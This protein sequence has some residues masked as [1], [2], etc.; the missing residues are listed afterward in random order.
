MSVTEG[1]T[2]SPAGGHSKD[3]VSSAG[4]HTVLCR[5]T[6]CPLSHQLGSDGQAGTVLLGQF[7]LDRFGALD[8]L[9]GSGQILWRHLQTDLIEL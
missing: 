8:R 5:G 4:R 7:D 6:Q 3:T 1:D 9:Q 2:V